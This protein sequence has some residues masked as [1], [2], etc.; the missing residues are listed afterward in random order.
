ME[1]GNSK[2]ADDTIVARMKKNTITIEHIMP[3]TLT[4]E[5]KTELGADWQNVYEKYLHT[6]RVCLN[7]NSIIC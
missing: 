6:F 3:Q 4:T 7:F 1:N 2:E 5:W